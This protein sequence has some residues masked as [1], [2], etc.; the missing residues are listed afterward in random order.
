MIVAGFVN[1]KVNT[2]AGRWTTYAV[3]NGG[4]LAN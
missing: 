1:K 4:E 3:I 2:S